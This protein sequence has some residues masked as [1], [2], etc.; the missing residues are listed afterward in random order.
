MGLWNDFGIILRRPKAYWAALGAF[1]VTLALLWGYF[2]APLESLAAFFHIGIGCRRLWGYFQLT[3]GS[4]LA[5]ENDF[6]IILVPSYANEARFSKAIVFPMSFI[7][8]LKILYTCAS[9]L[10]LLWCHIEATL[11]I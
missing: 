9:T 6:G 5:Y 4:L 3:L 7:G 10:R 11:A 2:G 1:E 8:F